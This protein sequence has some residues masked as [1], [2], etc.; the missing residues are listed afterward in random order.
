MGGGDRWNFSDD[1]SGSK[2]E[3]RVEGETTLYAHWET[4][5]YT[6]VFDGSGGRFNNGADETKSEPDT[7]HGTALTEPLPLRTGYSLEGW[8]RKD[9]SGGDWG[10][11]WD[12]AADRVTAAIILY[13]RWQPIAYT[14][15]F[16][17]NS[18]SSV[19]SQGVDFGAYVSEPV[20]RSHQ[21]VL[22]L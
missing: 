14:V 21:A 9:G 16:N 11:Q 18:G 1:G 5:K 8:Y 20:P 12:F 2:S 13:A 10:D 15:S 6:V 7:P 3:K 19:A 17:S 4:S 22:Q